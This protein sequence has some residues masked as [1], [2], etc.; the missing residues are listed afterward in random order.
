MKTYKIFVRRF[1]GA[2]E[3]IK[4]GWSWPSMI[5]SMFWILV[6]RMWLLSILLW[7][8][9]IIFI[10]V[11]LPTYWFVV[12]NANDQPA[13]PE[14]HLASLVIGF[15]VLFYAIWAVGRAICLGAWGNKLRE[16]KLLYH[17]FEF[18]DIM[19]ARNPEDVLALWW[20]KN[21]SG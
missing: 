1:D 14:V 11:L 12:A 2:V 15:V 3:V 7:S 21:K 9:E 4:Q 18:T 5:F 17:Y 16:N 20:E 8:V 19:Q 6:K 13:T 10:L